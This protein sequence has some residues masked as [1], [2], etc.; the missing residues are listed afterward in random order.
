M[1]TWIG[2]GIRGVLDTSGLDIILVGIVARLILGVFVAAVFG[3]LGWL[4]DLWVF[5]FVE[6]TQVV[7]PIT[8]ILTAAGMTTLAVV[9]VWWNWET[10]WKVKAAQAAFVA[11]PVTISAALTFLASTNY[12]GFIW[13][14]RGVLFNVIQVCVVVANVF[15]LGLYLHR[16]LYKREI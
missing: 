5:Q 3:F 13:F 6:R 2:K 9:L 8:V 14:E 4:L 10:P 1:L 16:T 12:A 11:L 15:A 7:F